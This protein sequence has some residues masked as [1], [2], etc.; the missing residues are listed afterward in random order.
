MSHTT[1][2]AS[3]NQPGTDSVQSAPPHSPDRAGLLD[4]MGHTVEEQNQAG[5]IVCACIGIGVLIAIAACV[6][7]SRP[8]SPTLVRPINTSIN[9][10]PADTM[11]PPQIPIVTK[12]RLAADFQPPR[13]PPIPQAP[14]V[15]TGMLLLGDMNYDG[16]VNNGDVDLFVAALTMTNA[17]YEAAYPGH[18]RIIADV[19]RDCQV[20]NGDIDI[21]NLLVNR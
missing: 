11:L 18:R 9:S 14:S 4:H 15:P 1:K 19:N 13:T 6:T 2:G 12:L 5:L 16:I 7:E 20:N 8:P 3:T 10:A 21:F 17:E